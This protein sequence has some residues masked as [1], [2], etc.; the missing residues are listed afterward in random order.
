MTEPK[1][2]RAKNPTDLLAAVPYLLGFHPDDSVVLVTLGTAGTPVHA[3]QDLPASADHIPAVVRDLVE[4]TRRAGVTRAAVV[5]YSS[6]EAVADALAGALAR[7]L[8]RG[9]VQ[10][11]LA[12]RA[13][14]ERWYCLGEDDGRCRRDC[15]AEGTPYDLARHP[16]TLEAVVDGRV[17][18]GSRDALRDSLVSD[19]PDEVERVAAAVDSAGRRLVAACDSSTGL[20]RVSGRHHLVQEGRWVQHRVGRFL[21]DG[22]RLD[23][24]DVGRLVVAVAAVEV[25][26]VA[27]AQMSRADAERHVD[28]WRDV[29]RRSPR[30]TLAAPA[31]LLAFAAWLSG[32]GALAWCAVDRSQEAEPGYGLAG[33]VTQALAGAVP[34]TTWKPL[35]AGALS[36]FAG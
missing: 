29:V 14:G 10:V 13:D 6:D 16:I 28:L 7:S 19:D 9:R 8:R 36:L 21:R 31:A 24:H 12:L 3:R 23:S 25:R 4:V 2:L 30:D 1:T 26:D 20:D 35:G 32:D 5:V 17:V 33:L 34:P 11:A 15:P 27:W 22:R 18:H